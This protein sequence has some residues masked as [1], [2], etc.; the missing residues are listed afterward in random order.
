MPDV[1]QAF[2]FGNVLPTQAGVAWSSERHESSVIDKWQELPGAKLDWHLG[3]GYSLQGG[4]IVATFT[5]E[6]LISRPVSGGNAAGLLDITFGGQQPH[7]QSDNHRY[8][9]AMSAEEWGSVTTIRTMHF[10]FDAA[11]VRDSSLQV[12]FK[13]A[14]GSNF[15]FQNWLLKLEAYP[16]SR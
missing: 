1:G 5:A 13:L 12:I 8:A 15:G 9:T 16:V 11:L 6:V 14:A 3:P 10:P 7:P 4:L 2:A